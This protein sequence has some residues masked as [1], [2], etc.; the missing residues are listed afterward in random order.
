MKRKYSEAEDVMEPMPQHNHVGLRGLTNLG[1]TCFMNTI[2]QALCH[3]PLFRNYFLSECHTPGTCRIAAEA[4]RRAADAFCVACEFD[5][6]VNALYNGER[7][8]HNPHRFLYIF[9]KQGMHGDGLAYG[10]SSCK[11]AGY[12]QHD[13]HEFLQVWVLWSTGVLCRVLG[14]TVMERRVEGRPVGT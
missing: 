12:E 7:T 2:C 6:L 14:L 3:N 9:W 1:H 8:T 5:A 4:H 10:G 11:L 13:A